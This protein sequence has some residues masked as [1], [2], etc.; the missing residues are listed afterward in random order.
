MVEAGLRTTYSQHCAKLCSPAFIDQ[1]SGR[2][3]P[4]ASGAETER[5]EQLMNATDILKYGHQTVLQTIEGFPEAAWEEAGAC[6]V[7][8]VKDIIAHLASYEEV[9]E[10]VLSTFIGKHSAPYRDKFTQLGGHF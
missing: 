9:L 2:C 6:G 7:W 1:R 4:L 8:S 3:C 10:D 5:K